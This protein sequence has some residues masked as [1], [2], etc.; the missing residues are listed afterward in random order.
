[1]RDTHED[2]AMISKPTDADAIGY[3][4]GSLVQHGPYND[5]IYLMKLGASDPAKVAARLIAKAAELG[6]SKVFAKIP[7]GAEQAFL[8]SGFRVEAR[9]PRFYHGRTGAVFMGFYLAEQRAQEK[10]RAELD[11]LLTACAKKHPAA[12]AADLP[13]GF[14]LRRCT[15][16][17]AVEMSEI[18]SIVFRTYPF[19]IDDPY[20]LTRTMET[21]VHY[22]GVEVFGKLISLSSA[23]TDEEAENVEMTD[24]ATLPAWRGHG[25]AAHL[26]RAMEEAMRVR[27][28]KTAY[29]ISRS[30]SPGMN[31]TF[32]RSG[33]LY[34]G[35][36]INN[37]NISGQIESMNVWYKHLSG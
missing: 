10:D 1:M 32:S 22:F 24:F 35:R 36:V 18:Y 25:L 16:E 21:H 4:D 2:P 23:E 31:L 33:Y 6:Y 5:R 26:L 13:E 34:G 29:T 15:K 20:Y 14:S 12:R 11:E 8:H 27:N 7:D 37:T 9:I 17:D 30:A 19:P 3:I 28:I